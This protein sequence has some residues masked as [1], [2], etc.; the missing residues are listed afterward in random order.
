MTR[1]F[2]TLIYD[3]P[4][5]DHIL[6]KEP[7]LLKGGSEI[8]KQEA[9][10]KAAFAAE[11]R[12]SDLKSD[13]IV[14]GSIPSYRFSGDGISVSIS[15]VGGH[16]VYIRRTAQIGNEILSVNQ[17]IEKAKR[18]LERMGISGMLENYYYNQDGICIVN[19]A[20]ID[21]A[22]ICYTDLIKVVIAM[23]TGAL[24]LD[25]ASGYISNHKNRAFETP[26]QTIEEAMELVS[27]KLT[28]NNTSLALIPI[29]SNGVRCYELA[30]TDKNGKEILVYINTNTLKE[31]R[32]LIL[33]K[34][35]GGTLVK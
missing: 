25:E 33:L 10:E 22:T 17:A 35:D 20:Y 29:N 19:F 6:E 9:L 26:T 16:I 12:E 3:G 27:N 18:Q 7:E 14:S 15:K 32:V 8:T 28:V 5:S 31:E 2:P 1:N 23:D 34:S 24:M 30:C 21:G 4:Y 13:G 11:C